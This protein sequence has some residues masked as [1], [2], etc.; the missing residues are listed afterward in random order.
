MT[1]PSMTAEVRVVLFPAI[2]LVKPMVVDRS[3][4]FEPST[5]NAPLTAAPAWP[6]LPANV[7][8]G[9]PGTVDAAVNCQL[10]SRG[11]VWGAEDGCAEF[12]GVGLGAPP[13]PQKRTATER[14]RMISKRAMGFLLSLDI[15]KKCRQ[16]CHENSSF[17][18]LR[19]LPEKFVVRSKL[20]SGPMHVSTAASPEI[21]EM[22]RITDP[23]DLVAGRQTQLELAIEEKYPN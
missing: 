12:L 8:G 14:A 3:K 17:T 11:G 6:R 20:A 19:P 21:E 5:W 7:M 22:M 18:R 1:C 2:V 9:F 4:Q 16:A 10:P 13:H 23:K 15:V